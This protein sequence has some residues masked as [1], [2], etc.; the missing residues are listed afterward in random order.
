MPRFAG[1]AYI[2]VVMLDSKKTAPVLTGPPYNVDVGKEAAWGK[3]RM[4]CLFYL[5]R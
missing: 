4:I 3:S 1:N 2:T 5:G